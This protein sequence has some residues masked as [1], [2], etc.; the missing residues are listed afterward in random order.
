MQLQKQ[1][2]RIVN[3]NEYTKWIIV[4]PPSQIEELG[5]KEGMEL[6]SYAK[7]KG[8][9]VKPQTKP[10]VKPK[11]MSYEEFRDKI[12]SILKTEPNGLSWSE[13]RDGLKLPQKVPNNLW[14]RMMEKDIGLVRKLDNKTAKTIWRLQSS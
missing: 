5:W 1:I 4:I 7:G 12:S 13:I 10:K 14:V 6:E 3:G 2:S 8:L 9:I 11:K